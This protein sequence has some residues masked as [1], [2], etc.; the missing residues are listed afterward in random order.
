LAQESEVEGKRMKK[1]EWR[2]L[3]A[4]GL[5]VGL[6]CAC[7]QGPEPS[8]VPEATGLVTS[9]PGPGPSLAP[10]PEE[11]EPTTL[12]VGTTFVLDTANPASGWYNLPLRSLLFDALVEE[13]AVAQFVPGLAESW[14]HAAGGREWTFKIREGVTFHD[15][16]PCTAEEVSWSLNWAIDNDIGTMAYR[17][18]QVETVEAL[19]PTTLRI[20]LSDPI[21]SLEPVLSRVWIVPATVWEGRSEEE[22]HEFN[23]L[24]AGTGTGP[25]MLTAWVGGEY[26]TLEANPDYW[27]GTPPFERILYLEFGTED[28][29]LQAFLDGRIDV[30]SEGARETL[31]SM[32]DGVMVEVVSLPTTM[33]DEL[34]LNS[35]NKGTQPASL[36][37]PAVRLAIAYSIDQQKIVDEVYQGYAET[38][39]S[40]VPR[41]MSYWHE[42]DVPGA[43][44]DPVEANRLLDL[45]GYEDEN[46]D[47]TR[48]DENGNSLVY[49]LYAAYEEPSASVT[50][51]IAD[52]LIQIGISTTVSLMA[53]GALYSVYPDYDFDLIYWDWDLDPDPGSILGAFTC[54]RRGVEGWNDSGF[55][56]KEYDELYSQQA[57]AVD[58]EYRRA[59]V[60]EM[61]WMLYEQRPYVV[62]SYPRHAQA[63]RRDR[64]AGVRLDSRDLMWKATL[65]QARPMR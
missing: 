25:Y 32:E 4:L 15:G 64:M 28:E 8:A 38:A 62:L 40:V 26:L 6:L 55:C 3:I 13:G 37:D 11:G 9:S 35:F 57:E 12:R 56:D 17:L 52:N 5:C 53:E 42:S 2:L 54:D 30:L 61:Q 31:R 29:L 16:S 34:I 36:K 24:E 44:F 65:L 14:N 59:L 43:A 45:N 50:R 18:E 21:A 10:E 33:M 27:G 51:I 58:P 1:S 7:R 23:D 63:Y 49:R 19:D 41:S 20:T 46:R 39:T 47:G 60:S 22:I 48:E